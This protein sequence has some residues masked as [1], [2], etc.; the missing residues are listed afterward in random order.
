[1]TEEP[2]EVVDSSGLTDANW[3]DIN[4]LK[5]TFAEGGQKALSKGMA[6]LSED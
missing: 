3:A 4:R 1:M 2:L 5:R 6:T